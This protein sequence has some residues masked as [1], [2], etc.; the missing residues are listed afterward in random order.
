[1]SEHWL[2]STCTGPDSRGPFPGKGLLTSKKT[3]HDDLLLVY[4]EQLLLCAF[5]VHLTPCTSTK[6]TSGV[7]ASSIRLHEDKLELVK[8]QNAGWN[9]EPMSALRKPVVEDSD[10]VTRHAL[11]PERT[12]V[13]RLVLRGRLRRNLNDSDGEVSTDE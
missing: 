13:Q 12:V 5:R 9:I 4:T 1:M 2:Q 3:K 7:H 10:S 11:T 8:S 6:T